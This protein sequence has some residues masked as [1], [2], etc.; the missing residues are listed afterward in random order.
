MHKGEAQ[1]MK[2]PRLRTLV[3]LAVIALSAF[4]MGIPLAARPQAKESGDAD[5]ARFLALIQKWGS[6]PDTFPVYLEARA[7][8]RETGA[9]YT[10]Q[11]LATMAS[12]VGL[13]DTAVERWPLGPGG[14]RGTPAALPSDGAT[15]VDAAK[16]IA[17]IAQ[18]R[19]V[20]IVNEA[21]HA[22][23]TRAIFIDLLPR[24]RELGFD[25]YCAETLEDADLARLQR[26]G[27]PIRRSG[28]YSKEPLFGEVLRAAVRLGF[29]LCAYESEGDTQQARETGQ[30]ENLAA[31]LRDHPG[32]R[33]LVHA[34]YGHARKDITV[35]DARPMARELERLAGID[36]LTVDQTTLGAIVAPA[37][38]NPAYR[39]LWRRLPA[40]ARASVFLQSNDT[41]WSL[42]PRA[43]DV[44][45]ILPAP[46]PS[47]GRAG[48]LWLIPGKVVVSGFDA[49][50]Q[51]HYPC[52][53]EALHAGED[54]EAVPADVIVHERPGA[55]VPALALFP[56]DYRI[57]TVAPDGT[58]LREE[59]LQV[60]AQSH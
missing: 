41:A 34:G 57:R 56:G 26:E 40:D 6:S 12:E 35:K 51:G 10:G 59:T 52:A 1:P 54:D 48:W 9:S 2:G 46:S 19:R 30:A 33:I 29:S 43:Y 13:Y 31:V 28:V 24:L 4:V 23:Q 37:R 21:H 5:A 27:Y 11:I 22:A 38:E 49:D 60:S 15:V 25:W 14:T 47:H 20:V 44:S 58:R 7:F 16:A 45:V 36:P 32:A 42:E 50:C 17:R 3:R 55:P 39:P 8:E 18:D 53:I